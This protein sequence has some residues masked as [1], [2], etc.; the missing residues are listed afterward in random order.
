MTLTLKQERFVHEL[1]KGNSQ[2]QAYIN[3]GYS[4]EGKSERYLDNKASQMFKRGEIKDRYMQLILDMQNEALWTR[5][6][7]IN[8]YLGMKDKAKKEIAEKGIKMANMTMYLKSIEALNKLCFEH[9]L[10]EQ[11][12]KA[13]IKYLEKKVNRFD[14]DYNKTESELANA[15]IKLAGGEHEI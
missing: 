2:R 4:V 12:L 15:L 11:K 6:Q 8:E 9:D 1:V 13:Q 3:A 7:A 5:E 10:Q 14:S